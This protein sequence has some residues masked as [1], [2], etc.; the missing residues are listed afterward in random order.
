MVG[1]HFLLPEKAQARQKVG[2][3]TEK[4]LLILGVPAV[5]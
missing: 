2:T 4:R 1:I 3:R 5:G